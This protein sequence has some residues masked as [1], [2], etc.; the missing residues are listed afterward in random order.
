[1]LR[2]ILHLGALSILI[3]VLSSPVRGNGM[4]FTV[5]G[6]RPN[7]TPFRRLTS[8][9]RGTTGMRQAHAEP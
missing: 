1:M 6:L 8:G 4:L 3:E 9:E 2:F 7:R 5:A